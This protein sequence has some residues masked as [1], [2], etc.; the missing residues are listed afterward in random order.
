[1]KQC[2]LELTV[3]RVDAVGDRAQV[4]Y[5]YSTSF[6][7]DAAEQPWRTETDEK[8]MILERESG[9]WKVLSGF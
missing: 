3:R 1:M 5:F 6:Q 2:Q 4:D 9:A 7:I 8:R